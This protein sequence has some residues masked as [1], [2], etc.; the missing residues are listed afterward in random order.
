MNKKTIEKELKRKLSLLIL[1][2]MND[3]RLS[4]VT[5]SKLEVTPDLEQARIGI[6]VQS[7]NESSDQDEQEENEQ[8]QPDQSEETK[9]TPKTEEHP[10]KEQEEDYFQEDIQKQQESVDILKNAAGFLRQEIA[11][12]TQFRKVPEL[13]FYLDRSIEHSI[14]L[15]KLIDKAVEED[16]NKAPE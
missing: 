4:F 1:K 8:S 7:H 11:D 16:R 12:V 6:S 10:D 9:N 5:I 13:H 15:R 2:K 14:R 3:P